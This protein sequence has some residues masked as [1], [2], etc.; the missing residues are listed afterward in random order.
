MPYGELVPLRV[1]NVTQFAAN[2][3]WNLP[4]ETKRALKA[5]RVGVG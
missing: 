4:M 1:A 5:L 3:Q 2:L